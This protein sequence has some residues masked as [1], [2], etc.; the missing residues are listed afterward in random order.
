MIIGFIGS[1]GTGKTSTAQAYSEISGSVALLSSSRE[2]HNAGLPINQEATM[3]TQLMITVA[4]A[5]QAYSYADRET[6]FVADRTPL[7][8]YA[9]TSYQ[10]DYI[11]NE[12]DDLRKIYLQQTAELV[13][14]SMKK[15]SHLFY[16]PI[17]W[18]VTK[19]DA[20]KDDLAYQNVI[21]DR[22]V[23]YMYS[24]GVKP[25]VVPNVSPVERAHFIQASLDMV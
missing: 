21:D 14:S 9:Y 6:N 25:I 4:R 8:S 17:Y 10:I 1:H 12:N 7:D 23:T 18:P 16:F 20:R 19:D 22:I 2:I 24:L 11:W 13:E 3:L 15:Y 5:N